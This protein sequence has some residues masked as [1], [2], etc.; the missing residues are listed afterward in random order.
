MSD[1]A[2][3]IATVPTH[4]A[5]VLIASF[6]KDPVNWEHADVL[7]AVVLTLAV[8]KSVKSIREYVKLVPTVKNTTLQVAPHQVLGLHVSLDILTY[9]CIC[10]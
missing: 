9:L 10:I 6:L 3:P 5:P 2:H 7:K 4:Q 1:F 8:P